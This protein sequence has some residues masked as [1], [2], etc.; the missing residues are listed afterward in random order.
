MGAKILIVDDDPE[1]ASLIQTTLEQ[2]G[3]NISICDDGEDVM[4][5][6]NA[7]NPDL[8]I[9]DIMLPGMDGYSLV[10]LLAD[11]EKLSKL[12]IIVLS[13]LTPS[14]SMFETFPQVKAFLGKP[15]KAEELT[16]A[17]KATLANS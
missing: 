12:P 11:D 14:R 13:A 15:F 16:A 6:L 2:S 3:Y 1:M 9:T 5:S 7:F 8:L 10:T 17:V 4:V